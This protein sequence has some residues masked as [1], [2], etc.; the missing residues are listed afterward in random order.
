MDILGA[1]IGGF[2][3]LILLMT[4]GYVFGNNPGY[5]LVAIGVL[6]AVGILVKTVIE[7]TVPH[8]SQW[9]D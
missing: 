2:F 4:L 5:I 7:K 1:I 6:L 8:D 3:G 9:E